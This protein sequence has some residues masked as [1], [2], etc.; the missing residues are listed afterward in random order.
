[1]G[2]RLH[3]VCFT[4]VAYRA[5]PACDLGLDGAQNGSAESRLITGVKLWKSLRFFNPAAAAAARISPNLRP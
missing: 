3:V 4:P 1:L 2:A 5:G